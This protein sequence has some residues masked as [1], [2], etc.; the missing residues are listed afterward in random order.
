M[1][2]IVVKPNNTFKVVETAGELEDLQGL[3][4]GYIEAVRPT[5]GYENATLK[6]GNVFLCDEEGHLKEKPLNRWGTI[7]Y[8][9]VSKDIHPIVGDI[10]I[11]G[12]SNENFRGLLDDEIGY[13]K[14]WFMFGG[15]LE[16]TN[17]DV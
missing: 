10:V 8:N 1:K 14:T 4:G 16:V 6:L 15:I 17:E 3:V 13:Y 11:I 5:A 12:E 9:G 2:V 7:L